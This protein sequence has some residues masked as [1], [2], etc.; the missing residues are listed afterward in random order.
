M[1]QCTIERCDGKKS[2][3]KE[4]P[5]GLSAFAA[6]DERFWAEVTYTLRPPYVHVQ[7]QPMF[8]L[9]TKLGNE[10]QTPQEGD[11]MLLASGAEERNDDV[12]IV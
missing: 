10:L 7:G 2:N 3:L 11:S 5:M 12:I 9:L 1:C 6:S 8:Q 4:W